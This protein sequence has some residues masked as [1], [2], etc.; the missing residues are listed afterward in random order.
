[1]ENNLTIKKIHLPSLMLVLQ[2]IFDKGA[3]Y[4][5]IHGVTGSDED[6]FTISFNKSYM[7]EEY[8][9][10]FDNFEAEEQSTDNIKVKLSDDDLNQLI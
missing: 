4:I 10:D 1:M 8:V 6:E 5:D 9:D 7:N 3:D 2:A